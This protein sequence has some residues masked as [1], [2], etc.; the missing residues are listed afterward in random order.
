KNNNG[1][2]TD[3]RFTH[4]QSEPKFQMYRKKDMSIKLD[5]RFKKILT[6]KFTDSAP[7]DEYGR[8]V[9]KT[10]I[11]KT[12]SKNFIL[13][14]NQP[15]QE[16]KED[17]KKPQSQPKQEQKNKKQQPK[18]VEE[19]EDE[20]SDIEINDSDNDSIN[21]NVDSDKS[22]VVEYGGFE[23][24]SD[25]ESSDAEEFEGDDIESESEGELGQQEDDDI[26]RGDATK[27]FAV[28]NCDWDNI[29]SKDLFVLLNSFVPPGG[30]IER[31][32]VY[33]SDYGLEQMAKEKSSG[34]SK[35]IWSRD[36][37]QAMMDESTLSYDKVEDAESLDGKGFNL[38][39]LRQYE[40]SKLKYYYAIV[41]CSSVETANKIYE[42]CEGMEIEDTANVLDL[43]FVPDDQEFKNPPRDSCDT[44]PASTKGFG[45]STSVLKGTTVDFTWDVDKS[46]K[47]LLTK[48][49][50]K[51]DAREEDLRAYLAEPTSSEDES[52][53]SETDQTA[54]R[55]KLRNKYKSLLLDTDMLEAK[56]KDDVQITFSSAFS[57]VKDK[58][59]NSDD[60]D[61]E[62]FTVK[63]DGDENTQDSSSEEGDQEGELVVGSES[64]SE[65]DD[66]SSDS[67]DDEEDIPHNINGDTKGFVKNNSLNDDDEVPDWAKDLKSDDE[68]EDD[69]KE[70]V[71]NTNL[72][73]LGKKLLKEKEQRENG[74][75]FTDYLQKKKEKKQQKKRERREEVS[76]IIKEKEEKD[77]QQK[78]NKSKGRLTEEEKKEQAELELLLMNDDG[79][80]KRGFSKK[81]LE[82]EAKLNTLDP[83]QKKKLEKKLKKKNE[84]LEVKENKNIDDEA[85]GFKIDVKDPRFGQI[86]KDNN[87]GLDPTDPKFLRTSA[88]VEI[89]NEKNTIRKSEKEKQEKEILE[90]RNKTKQINNN[91]TGSSASEAAKSN[92]SEMALNIKR[93]AEE[94]NNLLNSKK[95][96]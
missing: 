3:K 58:N 56:E 18:Q 8:K 45:F 1:V 48:N 29:D 70:M 60:D 64:D 88:M 35:E 51:D 43:R 31:I 65:A 46:R 14:Q 15:Q 72:S 94:R 83:H 50:S 87:F 27:R 21:S 90:R 37:D 12:I 66:E 23:Y 96:K 26:P 59:S 82:K 85:D 17:K 28:L 20:D 81:K 55:L 62:D 67:E 54:K 74:T 80:K 33:P 41:K 30:H 86:Y 13:E 19:E 34:P 40:L 2:I 47:K 32:T 92:L 39:K 89:L 53:D 61:D 44:L 49:Y 75:V 84:K 22:K 10:K 24:N 93:K 71:I 38:E 7:I 73:G 11:N 95:L 78:K 5:E 6:N 68:E 52:D 36:K 4:A 63:F 57:D 9:D 25:T 69:V 91:N 79:E 16:Q 77:K 76:Q 42:E